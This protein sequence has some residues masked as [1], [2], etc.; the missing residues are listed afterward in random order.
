M[1]ARCL[2]DFK[3]CV[4]QLYASNCTELDDTSPYLIPLF[5]S[6]E[7]VLEHG[8]KEFPS[9]FG[10]SKQYCWNVF[11]KL[12]K[13]SKEFGYDIPYSLSAALDKVNECKRVKTAIGKGRLLLR[14]LAKNG[15]LGDMVLL[16]KENK[17][18][19]LQFYEYSKAVL[20]N[21]VQCQIFYSFVADFTRIKF[22]LNIDGADF[23]DITWEIPVYVAKDFV[24]CSH[25]GIRVRFLDSYYIITELEK[26]F[27]EN[28]GDFFELGDVITALA[29]NVLRGKVVDLQK[30]FTRECRTLLR[31][32]VAKV[33]ASDGTYFKPIL[34]I[35]EKHGYENILNLDV[36][37]DAKAKIPVW[38]VTESLDLSACYTALGDGAT[39]VVGESPSLANNIIH[40]VRYVGSVNIG[41]RGDMSHIPETIETVLAE[42]PSPSH[43]M[44]VRVR[45][46]ELDVSVWPV[47]SNANENGVKDEPFLKH[48]YPSISAVGHRRQAA[49]Y[50]GYI[51]GD[52]TCTVATTFTAYV[53]LCVSKA[54][55]S[56]IVRGISKG[57]K[58]TNW[59][60]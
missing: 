21:D 2:A 44:P 16:L 28:G 34:N 60:M 4:A 38:P 17:S 47:R 26:E 41:S 10:E 33:R 58:R 19:L 53:F 8:L 36:D 14:I 40:S 12:T 35:L 51:A 32:E 18:F 5:A 11:E 1:A 3:A 46:G 59:T 37:S 50:F 20:T 15:S 24:P 27:Y 29:G 25:L 49:R 55:A 43:Y 48:A 39:D 56:R 22:E 52:S 7:K 45:L 6:I 57:F 9:L 13:G 30:I 31:F 54:E 42:N 23:L